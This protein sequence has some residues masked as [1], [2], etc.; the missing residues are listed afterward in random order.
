MLALGLAAEPALAQITPGAAGPGGVLDNV[1]AEIRTA[2]DRVGTRLG[3]IAWNALL[4]LLLVDCVLRAGRAMFSEDD[5]SGLIRGF[6]FHLGCVALTYGLI[7][8]LPEFVDFLAATALDIAAAAGAP[9]VSAS[10]FV[11]AGLE[12]AVGWLGNI[13]V[14]RPGTWFFLIASA[15]SVIVLAATVA[16]MIVIWA[17]LYL[18]A[19]AGSVSLMFVGLTETR[20]AG[21]KYVNGLVGKAFKLMGLLVIVAAT[22]QMTDALAAMDGAGFD[23]AMGMILIQIVSLVLITTLPGAL[24]GLIGNSFASRAGVMIGMLGGGLAAVVTGSAAGAALGAGAAG[25][26]G[27]VRS[28]AAAARGGASATEIAKAATR[29]LGGGVVAGGW[30]GGKAGAGFGHDSARHGITRALGD[31]MRGKGGSGQ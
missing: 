6:A 18:C 30:A 25:A 26:G 15:V 31:R 5:L 23:A 3:D 14:T 27:G 13:S 19:L 11:V 4:S 17:E 24:E 20:A 9:D 10:E 2:F 7:R 16:F 29:G 12:R 1:V 8:V 22:G 28:A 21:I